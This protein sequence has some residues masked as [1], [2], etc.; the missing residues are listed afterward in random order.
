MAKRGRYS[1]EAMLADWGTGDFTVRSLADKHKV[2]PA[3]AQGVVKGQPKHLEPIINSLVKSNQEVALLSEHELNSVEHAVEE[4]T[5]HIEFFNNATIRNIS[6]MLKN[7]I[8]PQEA[9][10]SIADH[11]LAQAAIK[12]GRETV[13]GKEPT[14]SVNIDNSTKTQNITGI[15][16][17]VRGT[18]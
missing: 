15:T 2:S 1:A 17:R 12:D 11:R 13:L 16:W 8:E 3:T 5:K 18:E 4:K 6:K 14:T 10:P 9:T 7:H